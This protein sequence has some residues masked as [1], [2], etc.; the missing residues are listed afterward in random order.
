MKA[1]K[2]IRDLERRPK[3][4][5]RHVVVSDEGR[6]PTTASLFIRVSPGVR[7]R[8]EKVVEEER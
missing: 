6:Y 2:R 7:E 1:N 5:V 3:S 8:N 4:S